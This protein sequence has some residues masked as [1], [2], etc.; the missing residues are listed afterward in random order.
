VLE[1]S[2]IGNHLELLGRLDADASG[3]AGRHPVEQRDERSGDHA[4]ELGGPSHG[5]RG[6]EGSGGGDRLGNEL[7]EDHL[8]DRGDRQRDR[9]GYPG[10][11]LTER[12]LDARLEDAGD[13]RLR[14]H[15]EK[16]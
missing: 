14:Q 10:R 2:T 6:L 11:H 7:A 1:F 15:A 4:V 12:S 16:Q 5:Q 9:N 3:E 13:G 8:H